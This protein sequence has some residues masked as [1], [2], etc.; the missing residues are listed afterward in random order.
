M[1]RCLVSQFAL[2]EKAQHESV[3]NDL[4]PAAIGIIEHYLKVVFKDDAA[5]SD[6]SSYIKERYLKKC[7]AE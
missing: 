6:A 5:N 7:F 1:N 3:A 4:F 2:L